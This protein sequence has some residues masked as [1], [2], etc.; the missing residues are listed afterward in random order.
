MISFA[1]E[2]LQ[3]VE[4]NFYLIKEHWDEVVR[5]SRPLD[6]WWELFRTQ[7]K[8][9]ELICFVARKDETVI[10]Y[11]VFQLQPHFHSRNCKTAFNDAI[12]LRKD[13]RKNSLGKFFLEY[14]DQQLEEMGVNMII[15]HVKPAVDFSGTLKSIGY[16]HHATVYA[17]NV[18]G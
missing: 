16:A 1:K 14:C 13:F 5:D 2:P 18:G 11:A 8:A 7:E 3:V 6:P 12:F 9:G 10:G 4:D 17:R 15:W